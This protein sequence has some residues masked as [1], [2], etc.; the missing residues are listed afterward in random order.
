MRE[1]VLV[2]KVFV[3]MG[4]HVPSRNNCCNGT[5]HDIFVQYVNWLE[6]WHRPK[7]WHRP[8]QLLHHSPL[9]QRSGSRQGQAAKQTDRTFLTVELLKAATRAGCVATAGLKRVITRISST[10]RGT[11]SKL[12]PPPRM[13]RARRRSLS[14]SR[15]DAPDTLAM[16]LLQATGGG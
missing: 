4:R 14:L 7:Q 3:L 8:R 11:F 16:Q 6:A 5:A 13:R 9:R 15:C 1:H 2:R 10:G 12:P